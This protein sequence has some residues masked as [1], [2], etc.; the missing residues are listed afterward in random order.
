MRQKN[1]QTSFTGDN[2]LQNSVIWRKILGRQLVK[3]RH[4]NKENFSSHKTPPYLRLRF[5]KLV[6][7]EVKTCVFLHL[8]VLDKIMTHII[9]NGINFSLKGQRTPEVEKKLIVE[10][11]LSR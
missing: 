5:D 10:K 11:D 2:N 3:A 8:T 4:T 1:K 6:A 9:T 7:V